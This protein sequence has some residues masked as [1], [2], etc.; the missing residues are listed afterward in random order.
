M[1]ENSTNLL[2]QSY[3]IGEFIYNRSYN[4]YEIFEGTVPYAIL[5]TLLGSIPYKFTTNPSEKALIRDSA[6]LLSIAIVAWRKVEIGSTG[7]TYDWGV[8]IGQASMSACKITIL[9]GT[10]YLYPALITGPVGWVTLGSVSLATNFIC[11]PQL[12][13]FKIASREYPE[14]LNTVN[15][16]QECPLSYDLFIEYNLDNLFIRGIKES[17][18]KIFVSN[19]LIGETLKGFFKHVYT[20]TALATDFLAT[21]VCLKITQHPTID[22]YG[23]QGIYNKAHV[24][25]TTGAGV[26]LFIQS[27]LY[28]I[29][30]TMETTITTIR[31]TFI[32]F[33]FV[34]LSNSAADSKV[35]IECLFG[36]I[37]KTIT[38]GAGIATTMA[39]SF[40]DQH[41]AICALIG[42]SVKSGIDLGASTANNILQ[43]YFSNTTE[44]A[45][46]GNN[47]EA[48]PSEE[49]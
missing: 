25:L 43:D 19:I 35:I 11:R 14:Y 33:I 40:K 44:I 6:I 46:A 18:P 3:H 7:I 41:K 4:W 16:D 42:I 48:L 39:C 5:L 28:T 49:L 12:R 36:S 47:Q 34:P 9:G 29:L 32:S 30:F 15:Q 8:V 27:S 24:C 10:T 21:Q 38:T 2:H 20:Y 17:I 26:G 22:L 1:T 13:M 31:E 23:Q 45:L 37:F